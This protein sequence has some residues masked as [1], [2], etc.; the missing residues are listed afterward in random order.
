MISPRLELA[1]SALKL[2][3]VSQFFRS[4][5]ITI[6]A[7]AQASEY[8]PVRN[9]ECPATLLRS[10]QNQTLNAQEQSYITG[11][12]TG[13]IA[14]AWSDW[15]GDGQALDYDM[16]SFKGKLPRI[17]IALGGGGYRAAQ[18]GAGVL[19]AL[20]A[21]NST[22][23]KS[24][25]GGLLQVATYLSASS[26]GSNNHPGGSWLAGSLILNDWPSIPDLVYGNGG[27]LPGWMLD[28]DLIAPDSIDTSDPNNMAFY[29]DI[30]ADVTAKAKSGL[31]VSATD[32][33]GRMV[34]Y[35]FLNGTTR[36]NFYENT[37]TAHGAGQLWSHV[38]FL[39]SYQNFSM[40]F[41]IVVTNSQPVG[42]NVTTVAPLGA[43]VYEITPFEFGSWDPN[44][45]T[46]IPTQFSGT[47]LTGGY[48]TNNTACVTGFDQASFI[49]GTSASMFNV[50]LD[51][52]SDNINDFNSENGDQTGMSYLLQQLSGDAPTRALNVAN[53]PNS[54]QNLTPSAF[55]DAASEWLDL[56]DGGSNGENV[57]L[58]NLF[59]KARELDVVVAIDAGADNATNSWPNGTSPLTA[60]ERISSILSTSHQQFPPIPSSPADFISTGV[61]QRPTF[62]GCDPAQNPPEY[63]LVIYLPN[64]PPLDGDAPATNAPTFQFSYSSLFT[65]VFLNQAFANTLGGFVPNTTDADPN[66]GKCLQCAAIDRAR[67]K[68]SPTPSRS[69]V[70]TTCFSQYCYSPSNPPSVSELPGRDY[71]FTDPDPDAYNKV[72]EFLKTHVGVLVGGI[73]GLLALIGVIIGFIFWWRRRRER[74]ATY[75]RVDELRDDDEPWRHYDTNSGIYEMPKLSLDS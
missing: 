62:F 9:V 37:S 13:P 14:K 70:C 44:L 53:W 16:T 17:G 3:L 43:V 51:G 49:M 21:R 22:A 71:N 45:S 41:P 5:V 64:S 34:A 38:P 23:K 35:H 32:L 46:M 56:I 68:A 48:P 29:G 40:P 55:G 63:P 15:L 1:L 66:F 12:E 11:R 33:W 36:S 4:A 69:D 30:L 58:G 60:S 54:F 50:L 20:D 6:L 28:L 7:A 31:D 10:V 47:R 18:Y 25:T 19:S 59:V 75:S 72:V 65:A 8:A 42:T 52:S 24:G 61:N 73:L 26:A 27:D 2:V 74:K 39:P 57:P 67:Y